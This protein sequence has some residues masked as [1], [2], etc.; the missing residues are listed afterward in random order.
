MPVEV[1]R[2]E[3]TP[4]IIANAFNLFAH[5]GDAGIGGFVPGVTDII[6]ASRDLPSHSLWTTQQVSA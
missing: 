3:A 4:A 2:S 5:D 1:G 6:G